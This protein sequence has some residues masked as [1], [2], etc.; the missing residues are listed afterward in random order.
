MRKT[1][2]SLCSLGFPLLSRSLIATFC[3]VG[4]CKEW[5]A[6]GLCGVEGG[7]LPNISNSIPVNLL[8]LPLSLATEPNIIS[9]P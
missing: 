9:L 1:Q 2:A 4:R 8:V 5:V 7:A 6:A 3:G